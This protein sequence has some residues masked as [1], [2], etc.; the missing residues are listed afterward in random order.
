MV[1]DWVVGRGSQNVTHCQLWTAD[2][3]AWG[4]VSVN[5]CMTRG[6]SDGRIC[7][8]TVDA[9]LCFLEVQALIDWLS[10]V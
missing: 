6:L 10:M 3:S 1:W 5:T 9:D 8:E 2:S 7:T 4:R